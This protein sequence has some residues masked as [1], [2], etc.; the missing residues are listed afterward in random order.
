MRKLL[1]TNITSLFY[2][3]G[4]SNSAKVLVTCSDNC[5]RMI[6]AARYH[7]RVLFAQLFHDSAVC[8]MSGPFDHLVSAAAK[9]PGALDWQSSMKIPSQVVD[10]M[11]AYLWEVKRYSSF[12]W[13]FNHI[14]PL[15]LPVNPVNGL[16]AING[17]P[18][19]LQMV[20]VS[21][22]GLAAALA[23]NE[24]A[25]SASVPC[26]VTDALHVV[27]YNRVSRIDNAV[28]GWDKPHRSSKLYVPSVSLFK[29]HSFTTERKEMGSRRVESKSVTHYLATVDVSRGEEFGPESS[30]KIWKWDYT[31]PSG[32]QY[33]LI[34]QVA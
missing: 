9:V 28:T 33:K 3:L 23:L 21:V 27:S 12:P 5:I 25:A 11:L 34:T 30:L 4:S 17:Y 29:F 1:T 22:S 18:G 24:G 32:P 6:N 7:T 31:S 13:C 19:Q 16:V 20:D 15:I 10:S 8:A 2:F 26:A 14:L